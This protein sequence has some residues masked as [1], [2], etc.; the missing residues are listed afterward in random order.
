MSGSGQ[1]HVDRRL[2]G[3]CE[4]GEQQ[5]KADGRGQR[6]DHGRQGPARFRLQ[7]GMAAL[8]LSPEKMRNRLDR[9][10]EAVL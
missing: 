9:A 3:R 8:P 5:G 7:L 6:T 2:L 4:Y 10:V 1:L